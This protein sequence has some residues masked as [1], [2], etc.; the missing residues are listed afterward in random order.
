MCPIV[1]FSNEKLF[2]SKKEYGK[3]VSSAIVD[4]LK[5][6]SLPLSVSIVAISQTGNIDHEKNILI[7]SHR[8]EQ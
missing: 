1:K 4:V 7:L 6:Y 5:R 3:R 8:L 2:S